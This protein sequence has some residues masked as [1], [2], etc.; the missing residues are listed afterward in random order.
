MDKKIV[1][2]AKTSK[3]LELIA[4]GRKDAEIAKELECSYSSVRYHIDSL[5][6]TFRTDN[7]GEVIYLAMKSG[8]LK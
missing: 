2:G 8:L 1:L 6:R 7:R 3:V 4:K 5:Y